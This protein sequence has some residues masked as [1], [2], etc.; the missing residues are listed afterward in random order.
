LEETIL[1]NGVLHDSDRVRMSLKS[2]VI[3]QIE[4]GEWEFA[5]GI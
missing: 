3:R 5:V 2:I 1:V 4:C